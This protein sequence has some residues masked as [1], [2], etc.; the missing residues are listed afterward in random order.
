MKI[1]ACSPLG[2]ETIQIEIKTA[3]KTHIWDFMPNDMPNTASVTTNLKLFVVQKCDII[4]HC[5]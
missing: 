2:K 5:F 4:N 1:P 3:V